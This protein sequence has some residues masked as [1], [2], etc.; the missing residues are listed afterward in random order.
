MFF[1]LTFFQLLLVAGVPCHRSSGWEVEK[2][3]SEAVLEFVRTHPLLSHLPIIVMLEAAPGLAAS[4]ISRHLDDYAMRHRMKESLI[5]MR[6]CQDN[7]IGVLKSKKLN[8]D[9]R[10]CL[11][12]VLKYDLMCCDSNVK[13]LHPTNPPRKEV[14]R[15]GEMMRS[16]HRDEKTGI[17]NSK[18]DG[19]PDDILSALNQM[20]Y[21]GNVFWTTAKYLPVRAD[22][23]RRSQCDFQFPTNGSFRPKNVKL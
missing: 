7:A 12:F 21:W 4:N 15:L 23:I 14:E 3:T 18:L 19:A 5:Y 13:T 22:I 11:E 17:I 8:V 1:V 9:Y 2:A 10:Y 16:Y 20:L 6:E